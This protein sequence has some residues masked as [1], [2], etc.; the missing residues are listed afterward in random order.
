MPWQ[1]QQRRYNNSN[2]NGSTTTIKSISNDNNNQARGE[3]TEGPGENGRVKAP[4]T[5]GSRVYLLDGLGEMFWIFG[6]LKGYF[7]HNSII[8]WGLSVY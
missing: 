2:C 3:T 4:W 8:L 1:Q 5:R 7:L 6:P